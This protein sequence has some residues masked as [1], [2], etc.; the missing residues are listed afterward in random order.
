MEK[1]PDVVVDHKEVTETS[2]IQALAAHE[3][4]AAEERRLV[5]KLDRHIA[6]VAMGLYLIAFLDRA[7][8]GNA[9]VGGMTE[10]LNFPANGLSV[11]TSIFYV[12]YVIF[13]SLPLTDP[14][15]GRK[16]RR[17]SSSAASS[18]SA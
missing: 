6:P 5:W 17:P 9:A 7:N 2:E 1:T 13:V 15:D 18:P 10:D 3:L 14:A 16:P 8:I 11:A 4:D 12:T